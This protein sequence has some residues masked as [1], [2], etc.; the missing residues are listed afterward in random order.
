MITSKSKNMNYKLEFNED[1]Q[2]FHLSTAANR[3][4]ETNGWF[5]IMDSC[6]DQMYW[7]LVCMLESLHEEPYTK[8]LIF[9]AMAKLY[10]F[11]VLLNKNKMS[12][13]LNEN[14]PNQKSDNKCGHDKVISVR[15]AFKCTNCGKLIEQQ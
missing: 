2:Q 5:T 1:Q 14:E 10:N 15:Y 9:D 3:L 7:E 4:P 13:V 11:H 6:S 12:I 8:R